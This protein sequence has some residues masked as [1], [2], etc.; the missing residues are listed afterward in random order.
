VETDK[1]WQ[2]ATAGREWD[3]VTWIEKTA[4]FLIAKMQSGR[5]DLE[6]EGAHGFW[7]MATN[8]EYHPYFTFEWL[9]P[10]VKGLKSSYGGMCR[11]PCIPFMYSIQFNG[12]D[13]LRC[14]VFSSCLL[15][16]AS[17]Q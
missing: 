5:D 6:A 17:V 1:Q 12:T 15:P 8:K 16:F 2:D 9:Q 13:L 3:L 4:E 10:V 14:S 11:S 7:E